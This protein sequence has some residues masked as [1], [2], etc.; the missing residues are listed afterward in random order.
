MLGSLNASDSDLTENAIRSGHKVNSILSLQSRPLDEGRP[1]GSPS[2]CLVLIQT[3]VCRAENVHK[4]PKIEGKPNLEIIP[5]DEGSP[6]TL[7]L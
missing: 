3:L 4:L 6:Y 5:P 2:I 1:S 7:T